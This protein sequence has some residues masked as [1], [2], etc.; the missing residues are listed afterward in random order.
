MMKRTTYSYP[1]RRLHQGF[2][3]LEM[4]IAVLILS[5]GLLG[6]AALQ[7]RGQQLNNAAYVR[8]QAN[9]LAY[10]ITEKIRANATYARNSAGGGYKLAGKPGTPDVLCHQTICTPA[11][12]AAYDLWLWYQQ[13]ERALPD[14]KAVITAEAVDGGLHT[15]YSVQITWG[16]RDS[17]QESASETTKTLTWGMRV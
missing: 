1:P 6:I 14:G 10:E 4:L 11:Q 15:Q 8:T 5:V 13:L 3:M 9:L 7:T 2:T 17:E 12:L 16:L